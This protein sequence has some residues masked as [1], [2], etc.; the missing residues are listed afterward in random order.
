MKRYPNSKP[1]E[2]DEELCERM[3]SMNVRLYTTAKIIP[4]GPDY[5]N[6]REYLRAYNRLKKKRQA[7][8][9]KAKTNC[10]SNVSTNQ[11]FGTTS[12]QTL[13]TDVNPNLHSL[14]YVSQEQFTQ[15]NNS[16]CVVNQGFI[17]EIVQPDPPDTHLEY[18]LEL[19][20]Q[21]ISPKKV[22]EYIVPDQ[23]PVLAIL[24]LYSN[25]ASCIDNVNIL[26]RSELS[27]N[28]KD[29]ESA[30]R[31]SMDTIIAS[32]EANEN[33]ELTTDEIYVNRLHYNVQVGGNLDWRDWDALKRMYIE[34]ACLPLNKRTYHQLFLLDQIRSIYILTNHEIPK[35]IIMKV[36]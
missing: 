13:S 26:P 12:N 24:P 22:S 17:L 11:L 23:G 20:S 29:S 33:F 2:T 32:N 35:E 5:D 4:P 6:C 28:D 7:T 19:M 9:A 31:T 1:I 25:Y 8:R 21:E 30:T 16:S 15:T 14:Q 27:L 36:K 3:K 34:L 18:N 10:L